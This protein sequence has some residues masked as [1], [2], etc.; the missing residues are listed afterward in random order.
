MFFIGLLL[1]AVV[2][3]TVSTTSSTDAG[4]DGDADDDWMNCDY[5]LIKQLSLPD[6]VCHLWLPQFNSTH[7]TSLCRSAMTILNATDIYHRVPTP[8]GKS[9]IFFFKI[10]GPGKFWK[11][12]LENYASLKFPAHR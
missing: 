9:W 7:L 1:S 11:N 2:L 4:G 12:I 8:P 5:L 6:D 10:P 3:A